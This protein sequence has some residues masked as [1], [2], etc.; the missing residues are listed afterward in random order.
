MMVLSMN[1]KRQRRPNVRLGEVG[2]VSAAFACGISHKT[3]EIFGQKRWKHDFLNPKESDY[4][5]ICGFP[6][7]MSE[8]TVSDPG[9]SPRISA[10]M[11]QNRENNNPNSLKSVF[12]FASSDEVDVSKSKLNFGNITRKCRLMKRRRRN[13]EGNCGVFSGAWNSK[14]SPEISI[15]NRK[16]YGGKDVGGFTSNI[17]L[18]TYEVNGFRDF[19]DHETPATSKEASQNDI[20]EPTSNVQTQGISNEFLKE[21]A[22]YE[23]NNGFPQ[24]FGEC[25]KL[26]VSHS[27][28]NSVRRWLEELGF[29]KYAGVFEMHEVDEEALPLLTFEDL[30]DM[31]VLPVGPR[32]KLYTAIQQLKR[33]RERV[34]A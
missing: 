17:C 32:R 12:E 34:F 13:T 15:E 3:K 30:K 18:D 5:P 20:N 7:Q 8:F 19:S 25:D 9:V 31:G 21:G 27:S 14:I 2:D 6:Q 4:N 16:E 11:Q 23:G 29:G 10:D 33:G 26:K 22:C 28:V 24:S 1:S